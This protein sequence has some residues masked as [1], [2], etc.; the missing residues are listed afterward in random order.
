VVSFEFATAARL[1][2]GAGKVAEVPAVLRAQGVRRTLV[3]TNLPGPGCDRLRSL[4]TAAGIE[5]VVL[6]VDQEPTVDL[7]SAGR[8]RC[9]REGCDAVVGLGGGSAMDTGKAVAALATNE[10]DPLDYLEVV[11]SGRPLRARPLPFVAIPTTAGTGAEVTRNA[12]IGVPAAKVKV[13]LRSPHLLPILAVLDPD[14]LDGLPRSVVAQS[15]LDALSHL[16]EALVSCRAN[17]LTDALGTEGLRR[18]A[19][20]L[21]RAYTLGLPAETREDLMLASLCG[22]LC[23]A[24]GGLGAVHGF[25]APL[26][27]MLH[28]PHGALCAALLGPV[29]EANLRALAEREPEHPALARYREIAEIV[30]GRHG[31]GVEDGLD[32]VRDLCQA[33]E[34]RGLGHHGLSAG[35]IPALVAKAKAASSM[36]GNPVQLSDQE[37]GDVAMRAL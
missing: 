20:A 13:S 35:E 10:G 28:A 14:L 5:S 21:R 27:G 11:G 12:V 16:L 3:A 29:M 1:L 33:L 23:L 15:G 31:A 24:N 26:G 30:T 6:L 22:G 19:R 8:A 36:R 18:S 4:L 7:V 34:V 2:F 9:R 17:P 25:A 37:L 32:W